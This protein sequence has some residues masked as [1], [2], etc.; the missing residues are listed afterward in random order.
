MAVYQTPPHVNINDLKDDWITP[1]V[2]QKGITTAH[3]NPWFAAYELRDGFNRMRM[4]GNMKLDYQILPDLKLMGRFAYNSNNEKRVYRQ[5][6]SSYGGDGGGNNKP[7]GTFN[8]NITNMREMNTD[9][10]LSY[11]KKIGKFQIAPSAGGNIMTQRSYNMYAGGDPLVLA[12]LY[13]LSNVNRNGLTYYDNTYKKNIYSVYGLLNLSYNNMIFLEATGRNDWSSTLPEENRSY[14]YPSASI[15][16]LIN[17]M[18][19]LPSWVSLF[20]VRSGISQVGKDTD[21]Y[22]I[23][24]VLNQGTWGSNTM[25]SVPASLPNINLKPEIAKAF[26]IGSDISLFKNR[27]GA[28]FTYYKVKNINQILNASTSAMSGYT[29]ATINAGNVENTG[30]EIG[31]NAVPVQTNNWTWDLHVNFTRERSKLKELTPGINQFQFWESTS[32]YSWT[33][34][35]DYVGDIYTRDMKRVD[36]KNSQ[37]Y[38]WPILDSNGKLQINNSDV[39]KA[40]NSMHDFMMGLQ[41]NVSYKRITLSLSFDWR[42]GGEYYDQTMMRLARGGKVEY[43]HDNANSSTFTGILNNNSFNGDV[44]A[45]AAEIKAHPEIYQQD[46]WVGGRTQDLGGFLYSNSVYEGAFFPGVISDGEG[47]YIENFGGE[48]TRFV[49]AYDIFQPSGGYW[50]TATRY[51]W[52]YDASFV[53]LREIALSYTIPESIAGKLKAQSITIS[54]FLKNIVLYAANKT[55]QDPESI[56]NQIPGSSLRQGQSLWNASPIVMPIGFKVNITF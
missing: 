29:A 3:D 43:F 32:V 21:P 20:K 34:V 37:Y 18:V 22:V 19:T 56:Y 2:L 46:V 31:L 45:L 28:D 42:Q 33:R 27:L 13:T 30:I 52:I 23:A 50:N 36:D 16:A 51:K 54:G 47:G 7:Q 25:Y 38:G 26:E 8:E 15:S 17:E 49:K 39:I 48:G 10:L 55:N 6:W 1:N 11:T 41:T 24:T 53:K 12:G 35:G 14:F 40:G 9:F 5:A 4:F 44:N